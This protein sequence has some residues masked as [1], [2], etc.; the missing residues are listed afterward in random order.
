MPSIRTGNRHSGKTEW[1]I[2]ITATR[3]LARD[4]QKTDHHWYFRTLE[5]F[6]ENEKTHHHH[7]QKKQ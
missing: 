4:D 2:P 7:Q 3:L 6:S 5:I 1:K